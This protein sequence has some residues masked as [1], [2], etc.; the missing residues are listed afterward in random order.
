MKRILLILG[1]IVPITGCIAALPKVPLYV[2][3]DGT[4]AAPTQFISAVFKP[5]VNVTFVDNRTNVTINASGGG[6]GSMADILY[7]SNA[8]YTAMIANG[9]LTSNG[10]VAFTM[11]TSNNLVATVTA[12]TNWI[13]GN[14]GTLVNTN[15]YTRGQILATTVTS[16]NTVFYGTNTWK[17]RDVI[18]GWTD[19][20]LV[21]PYG[22]PAGSPSFSLGYGNINQD[23]ADTVGFGNGLKLLGVDN[24]GFGTSNTVTNA[25]DSV[26]VGRLNYLDGPYSGAFGYFSLVRGSGSYAFGG[27]LTNTA[28][29]TV[30]IGPT[31]DTKLT[32]G[33]LSVTTQNKVGIGTNN[34]QALL[35]VFGT[36]IGNGYLLR[37]GTANVSNGTNAFVVTTNGDIITMGGT[38]HSL[39]NETFECIQWT[40]GTANMNIKGNN[41]YSG[42]MWPGNQ[43]GFIGAGADANNVQYS[44][45]SGYGVE[46]WADSIESRG[47]IIKKTTGLVGIG[48]NA[49]VAPLQVVGNNAQNLVLQVGTTNRPSGLTLD[50]NNVLRINPG[51]GLNQLGCYG[52]LMMNATNLIVCPGADG[53]YTNLSGAS[54][55]GVIVSNGFYGAIGAGD[56]AALTNLY[57]G[58]YR[59]S[60]CLSYMGANSGAYEAEVFTNLVGCEVISFKDTFANPAR[61]RNGSATGI[62]YLPAN[63]RTSF[64][65]QDFGA[66]TSVAVHRANIVIGTP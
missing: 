51:G 26:A 59:V 46:L 37:V 30:E 66:G 18:G 52:A 42:A 40:P 2:N 10:C 38:T 28:D 45:N 5:G 8:L 62:I 50:T 22:L 1:L 35:E 16:T 7:S 58:W 47:I 27:R 23:D 31:N 29:R 4:I 39:Y 43:R 20:R 55:Y 11:T 53:V 19:I 15:L 63:C 57:A 32:I 56:V 54:G 49:P 36:N 21:A 17:S 12:S 48:T 34:P 14:I 41:T 6:S 44:G 64:K 33:P 24:S 3:Q 65:I 61:L 9:S 13:A 60:V 25:N